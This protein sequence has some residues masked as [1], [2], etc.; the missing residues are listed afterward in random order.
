MICRMVDAAQ[1]WDE[2]G[3]LLARALRGSDDS[4]DELLRR[5]AA[6][7]AWMLASDRGFAVVEPVPYNNGAGGGVDLLVWA[8]ASRGARDCLRE[9]LPDIEQ[10]AR[11][12]GAR[13]AAFKTSRRG[14]GRVMPP[15]WSVRQV[16]W[17]KEV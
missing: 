1:V 12:L 14:F 15:G 17:A 5:C 13:C 2:A 9:H 16:T 6:G 10:L 4:A 7:L 11:S 8:A 3:P